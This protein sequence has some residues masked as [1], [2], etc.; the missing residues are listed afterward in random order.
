[1]I[2][3]EIG[4]NHLGLESYA[5]HYVK[6]LLN[7][8]VEAIT[9]QIREPSFYKREDKSHLN[10]KTEF[11]KEIS[12]KIRESGKKFGLALSDL[13]LF[14]ELDAHVD[15]YKILSKDF[16]SDLSS[17]IIK[18]TNKLVYL[19]TGNS[20]TSEIKKYISTFSDLKREDIS[21][22]HTQLSYDIKDV[23]L[24]AISLLKKEIGCKVS[25]G[26]HCCNKH[27]C[28][29]SLAYEP[30]SIFLYIKGN[31]SIKY[32]DDKHSITLSEIKYFSSELKNL[33][34]SIG[35]GAKISMKN[36]IKDQ[37]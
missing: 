20:S 30:H 10:L 35:D 17:K 16:G 11:Y 29:L 33:K 28:F 26:N 27:V 9:F 2:I 13:T 34:S 1:M 32:P 6:Q 7:T 4:L 14:E 25:F 8:Q 23:N 37:R 24:K 3:A 36:K 19:S 15:F 18:H 12:K 31:E 22:I 21:L 5:K